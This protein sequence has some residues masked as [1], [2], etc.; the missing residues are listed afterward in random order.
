MVIAVNIKYQW[1]AF[2]LLCS[3]SEQRWTA[4]PFTS[5]RALLEDFFLFKGKISVRLQ[6]GY[7]LVLYIGKQLF[8]IALAMTPQ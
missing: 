8:T 2:F 1:I 6:A 5:Q 3:A 4:F 7:S